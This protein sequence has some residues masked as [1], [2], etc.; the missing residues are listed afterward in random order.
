MDTRIHTHT[1]KG[2]HVLRGYKRQRTHTCCTTDS[3]THTHT[4]T[5]TPIQ[6]HMLYQRVSKSVQQKGLLGIIANGDV[7]MSAVANASGTVHSDMEGEGTRG[8]Q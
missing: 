7:L 1:H 3:N 5:H 6:N 8:W 2:L 4:H